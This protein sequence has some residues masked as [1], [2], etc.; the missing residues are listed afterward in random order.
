MAEITAAAVRSL[1][2]RTDLPMMR[3]KQALVEA[4]GDEEK[5]IEILASQT[6]NIRA[7][8]ADNATTEGRIFVAIQDD[9]SEAALVDFQCE[10]APV[11]SN[12]GFIS[13]GEAMVQ[14]LLNG[15]GAETPAELLSQESPSHSG[16][17][18]QQVLDDLVNKIAEKFDV[19]FVARMQGPVGY[20]VHHDGKTAA[21]FQASGENLNAPILRDVA[22]HIA[23]LKPTCACESDVDAKKVEA[24]RARLS[25]EAR[26]TGKPDNIIDKIVDGR[27]KNF[28]Q[29][30]G[31]LAAQ[32]FA[33]DETKTVA[34][35]L[36][37]ENLVPKAFIIRTIG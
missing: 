4:G 12:E 3:C 26:A 28:F 27:M 25:E 23:A 31:V 10:T 33:K 8:R 6:E 35:V 15:P 30:E 14:Q 17:T 9:G 24:E 7:K 37:A 22:M 29:T 21:M 13:L 32:A 1:R 18:L 36:A 19:N 2:E 5:A 16:Q 11:A 34:Q 20:Y